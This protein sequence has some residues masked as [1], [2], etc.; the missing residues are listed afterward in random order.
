MNWHFL[1]KSH[2]LIRGA[3]WLVAELISSRRRHF[4][5]CSTCFMPL[6]IT[7][8]L[9]GLDWKRP[10][11]SSTSVL[12]K[13][14]QFSTAKPEAFPFHCLHYLHIPGQLLVKRSPQMVKNHYITVSIGKTK[15]WP[16]ALKT[17]TIYWHFSHFS[18][19][20]PAS[21][22]ASCRASTARNWLETHSWALELAG[23]GDQS[24]GTK[25]RTVFHQQ[26]S[27]PKVPC[28]PRRQKIVMATR[29][30]LHS[31]G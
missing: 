23:S 1:L 6:Q 30:F 17:V 14:N 16:S 12:L 13:V 19:E 9:N 24:T 29:G 2:T 22:K 21:G 28:F 4:K 25:P 3:G 31:L 10:E 18:T 11:R 15:P 20:K 26:F 7:E 5:L 27:Q 8:P